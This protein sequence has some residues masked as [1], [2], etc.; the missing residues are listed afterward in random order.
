MSIVFRSPGSLQQHD[1]DRLH[2]LEIIVQADDSITSCVE[3]DVHTC[4]IN[5]DVF[6]LCAR[7]SDTLWVPSAA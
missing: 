4:S 2:V 3:L 7:S 6:P 1:G 5:V